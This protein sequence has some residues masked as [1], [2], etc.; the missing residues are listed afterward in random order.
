MELKTTI[1]VGGETV[2]VVAQS[3]PNTGHFSLL[4]SGD[5]WSDLQF[6]PNSYD[7]VEAAVADLD[8]SFTGLREKTQELL[9]EE[10][11]RQPDILADLDRQLRSQLD[12]YFR[13]ARH[14]VAANGH[15]ARFYAMLGALIEIDKTAV[16]KVGSFAGPITP[17]GR[18]HEK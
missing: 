6:H 7:A 1:S 18:P 15:S 5:R 2:T 14:E 12:D 8:G 9:T 10:Q 11:P 3:D 17:K 16:M 4:C 13:L